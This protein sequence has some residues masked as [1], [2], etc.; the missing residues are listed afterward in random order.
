MDVPVGVRVHVPN[1]HRRFPPLRKS[2]LFNNKARATGGTS[3]RA[4]TSLE[5]GGRNTTERAAGTG[6]YIWSTGARPKRAQKHWM[7]PLRS[8]RTASHFAT[9]LS[10]LM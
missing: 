5:D 8:S 7:T 3:L 2:C 10:P 9:G 6:G 1:R 4:F